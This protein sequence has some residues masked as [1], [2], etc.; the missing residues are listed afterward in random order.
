[1]YYPFDQ[2]DSQN[3][4]NK[5]TTNW[6]LWTVLKTHILDGE[7]TIFSPYNPLQFDLL[8]GDQ[9]KYLIEH[10]PGL[11]FTTDSVYRTTL[12]SYLGKLDQPST[13]PLTNIYGEDSVVVSSDGTIEYVYPPRDTLWILSKDIIQYHIKEDWFFDKE[14]SV[15]DV[16]IIAIAP[17]VYETDESG[18]ITGLKELFCLY[19]PHCRFVLNN[20]AVFNEKNDAQWISF[21]DLFWK[22]RFTSVIYKESNVY[23]RK[24]E[25]YGSGIESLME[26][27]KIKEEIRII[28]HYI[29]DY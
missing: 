29:W 26:A 14:R 27:E 5:N 28:E 19:F 17:V 2:Y 13:T 18:Q 25:E 3:N 24:I 20:Y 11:D 15:M 16:R 6:S 10:S 23:D 9:L 12:F 4:W 8:D 21:D 7:L 1:M 22:R